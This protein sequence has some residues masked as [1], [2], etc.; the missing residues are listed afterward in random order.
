SAQPALGGTFGS[1]I[2]VAIRWSS[3]GCMRIV[4]CRGSIASEAQSFLRQ[5]GC[6][7]VFNAMIGVT[8]RGEQNLV[9]DQSSSTLT[10]VDFEDSFRS[11]GNLQEQLQYARAYGGLDSNVWRQDPTYS[12]GI[13][14]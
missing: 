8:D 1:R 11:S 12:L 7:A 10:H 4:D 5:L 3:P 6:W 2:S 14:L 13:A 9:W